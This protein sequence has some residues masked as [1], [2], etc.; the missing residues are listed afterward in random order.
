[1][2]TSSSWKMEW[3]SLINRNA[4]FKF[5]SRGAALSLSGAFLQRYVGH[6]APGYRHQGIYQ[7]LATVSALKHI[8]SQVSSTFGPATRVAALARLPRA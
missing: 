2:Q 5:Q 6:D 7:F 1:M 8:A 3:G 4:Y